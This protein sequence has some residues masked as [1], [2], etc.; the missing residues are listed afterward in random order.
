[1]KITKK[2]LQSKAKEIKG[3]SNKKE[4]VPGPVIVEDE[5]AE[6]LEGLFGD[7]EAVK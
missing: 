1:M 7:I 2:M 5:S 3:K 4:K 6:N